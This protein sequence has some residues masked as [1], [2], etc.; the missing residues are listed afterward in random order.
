MSSYS[1]GS[2]DS[3]NEMFS[4][5]EAN[6]ASTTE[7]PVNHFRISTSSETETEAFSASSTAGISAGNDYIAA[8]NTVINILENKSG[9]QIG[10]C[11]D[12]TSPVP[13]L[14]KNFQIRHR[15]SSKRQTGNF[16]KCL[17]C[18]KIGKKWQVSREETGV[19]WEQLSDASSRGQKIK[20]GETGMCST[21][22]CDGCRPAKR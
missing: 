3:L 7:H 12:P 19:T 16:D 22:G 9:V 11:V 18:T 13:S 21:T 17:C 15:S 4:M 10:R 1:N 8:I 5:K 6:Y 20:K 14:C 2:S